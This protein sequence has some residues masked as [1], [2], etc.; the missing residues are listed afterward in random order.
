[1]RRH[2]AAW[3]SQ[4]WATEWNVGHH[5]SHPSYTWLQ[6]AVW[7]LIQRNAQSQQFPDLIVRSKPKPCPHNKSHIM[8]DVRC[9]I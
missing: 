7:V 1:M 5:N 8:C 3:G 6:H 2:T 4:L 9:Q